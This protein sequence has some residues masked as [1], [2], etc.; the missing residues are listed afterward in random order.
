MSKK[1]SSLTK[2]YRRWR[3]RRDTQSHSSCSEPLP[4]SPPLRGFPSCR[5]VLEPRILLDASLVDTTSIEADPEQP[6]DLRFDVPGTRVSDPRVLDPRLSDP[7]D[8]Q[9]MI[10]PDLPTIRNWLDTANT[11]NARLSIVVKLWDAQPEDRISLADTYSSSS[12]LRDTWDG[13][14]GELRL[15]PRAGSSISRS[16]GGVSGCAPGSA[17]G[18]VGCGGCLYAGGLGLSLACGCK[19]GCVPRRE[20]LGHGSALCAG[21]LLGELCGCAQDRRAA[22]LF[23][24]RRVSGTFF[25]GCGEVRVR[26]DGARTPLM[27]GSVG[28]RQCR[29]LEG[30]ERSE[31]R[32]GFL[33]GDRCRR[34]NI[35]LRRAEFRLTGFRLDG[36]RLAGFRLGRC[37]LGEVVGNE[38]LP[39]QSVFGFGFSCC[40]VVWG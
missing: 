14:R 23:W 18:G 4:F 16:G 27:A 34:R 29:G 5:M 39:T 11:H 36:F 28:Q 6:T 13:A 7:Q 33:A 10:T 40:V 30:V 1:K 25:L 21:R 15:E 19:R 31:G 9:R 17:A 24:R 12:V 37:G 35:W 38:R 32:S 22:A 26:D 2:F 8:L 20:K 3:T